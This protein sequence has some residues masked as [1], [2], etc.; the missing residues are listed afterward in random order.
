MQVR[1][2]RIATV[3]DFIQKVATVQREYPALVVGVKVEAGIQDLLLGD[4]AQV[5]V[6]IGGFVTVG[7]I[8]A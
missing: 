8:D 2:L 3:L 4:E 5:V 6:G 1:Q 7:V